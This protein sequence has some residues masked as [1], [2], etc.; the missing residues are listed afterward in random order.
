MSKRYSLLI[1]LPDD[2]DEADLAALLHQ[3]EDGEM[4]LVHSALEQQDT[5]STSRL[6]QHAVQVQAPVAALLQRLLV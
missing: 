2:E 1:D 4:R 3:G 5:A 6:L